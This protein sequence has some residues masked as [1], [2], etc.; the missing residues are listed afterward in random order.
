MRLPASNVIPAE[1][2]AIVFE[3]LKIISLI[4]VKVEKDGDGTLYL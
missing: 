4:S 2:Y 1:R 3:I